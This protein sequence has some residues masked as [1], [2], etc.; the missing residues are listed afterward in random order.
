MTATNVLQL[1]TEIVLYITYLPR[2]W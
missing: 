1:T 2:M